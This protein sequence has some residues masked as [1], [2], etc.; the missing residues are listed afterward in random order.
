MSAR[1]FIVLLLI[2][3][4]TAVFSWLN[5]EKLYRFY[6]EKYFEFTGE[7][8]EY[9]EKAKDLYTSEHYDELEKFL[10]PLLIVYTD[11]Y[12]LKQIAGLNYIK[13]GRELEGAELFAS[14]INGVIPQGREVVQVVRILF[15]NDHYGDILIFNDRG[16][17]ITDVNMSFYYGASLYHGGRYREALERLKYAYRNGFPG[18]EI[19]YYLGLVYEKMDNLTESARYMEQAYSANRRDQDVKVSLIRIYRKAGRF[20]EAEVF[21]RKRR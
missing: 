1:S 15:R 4:G 16:V 8:S 9:L 11:D 2:F 10:E 12:R 7:K 19:N 3:T 6:M 18:Y 14:S 21:F 5:H 20:S 17:M 13:L